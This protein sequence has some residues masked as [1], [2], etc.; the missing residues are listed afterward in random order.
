[1]FIPKVIKSVFHEDIIYL[2]R[3]EIEYLK[4][5]QDPKIDVDETVFHRLGK[6]NDPFFKE[7]HHMI[8]PRVSEMIGEA[9]KPSYVFTSMYFTGRG[10]C[11]VHTD[12]P[13]CKYTLDLC[14]N[15]NEPWAINIAGAN[16]FLNPNDAMLYSGTD[17]V[18]YREKIQPNNYCDL[19]FF[20]FVP[21]DFQGK[22]D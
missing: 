21:L 13:Q 8:T 7:L 2:I 4:T 18:H 16:Y 12:R 9:V 3:K 11:P 20:H 15:Q 14:V 10:F 19:V 1:M 6:H 17:H 5:R 22:L